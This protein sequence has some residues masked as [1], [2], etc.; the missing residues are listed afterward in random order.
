VESILTVIF[1]IKFVE[2]K[3]DMP[4]ERV[5]NDVVK[6][7]CSIMGVNRLIINIPKMI[8]KWAVYENKLKTMGAT[9]KYPISHFS[10]LCSRL[11]RIFAIFVA[12]II[13]FTGNNEV[14][15]WRSAISILKRDRAAGSRELAARNTVPWVINC[16]GE[17]IAIALITS[18]RFI[19][20]VAALV[21]FIL[22][23]RTIATI[24]S[25]LDIVNIKTMLDAVDENQ[26]TFVINR[27]SV[28]VALNPRIGIIEFFLKTVSAYVKKKELEHAVR[29]YA[30]T[31][32][33]TLL[34]KYKKWET[35]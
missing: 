31:S 8:I 10:C 21:R 14:I 24:T 6:S 3:Q 28:I 7:N 2:S 1:S 32:N 12:I 5:I 22:P 4:K 35:K 25:K 34:S 30:Y 16:C 13:W 23:M 11:D 27:P 9:L 26:W 17:R 29:K 19:E 18:A 20:N 33:P 15:P